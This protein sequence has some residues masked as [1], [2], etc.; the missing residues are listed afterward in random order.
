MKHKAKFTAKTLTY[1]SH[2]CRETRRTLETM[3]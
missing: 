1:L 2:L 3:S